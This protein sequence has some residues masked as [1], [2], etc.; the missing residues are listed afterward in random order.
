MESRWKCTDTS[1]PIFCIHTAD[2]IFPWCL[3]GDVFHQLGA[4]GWILWSRAATR[5]QS[6]APR[7]LTVSDIDISA[8]RS[9]GRGVYV[10]DSVGSDTST[11][12]SRRRIRHQLLLASRRTEH[13]VWVFA[14]P[15]RSRGTR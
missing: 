12:A 2:Y 14:R 10:S 4:A 13:G 1:T 9:V 5:A 6:A 3:G 15:S 11:H 7:M 8:A